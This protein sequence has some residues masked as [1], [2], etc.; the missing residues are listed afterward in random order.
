MVLIEETVAPQS[1]KTGIL[2]SGDEAAENKAT[3]EYAS[4]GFET[5]SKTDVIITNNDNHINDDEQI[6]R[7]DIQ[8]AQQRELNDDHH[9]HD[10]LTDHQ[11]KQKALED[12]NDAKLQGNNL[13]RSGQYDDALLKYDLALQLVAEVPSSEELRSACYLNRAT[14]FLKMEKYV[15]SI[16]DCTK[17]LEL[18][19]SYKK[20]LL[21]RAEAHEKLEHFEEAVA[22]MAK[23][24]EMEPSN[25]EVKRSA[26]RLEQLAR[27]KREKMKEEM[28]G[29]LKDVGNTLLGKFGM[30]VD[31]F[32][33]VQDPKTGSYSLSYQP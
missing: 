8:S 23:L 27:E 10:S 21:R 9:Y 14:C 19:P 32:K 17:A 13:Y 5:A 2:E 3:T 1:K 12:A 4:N 29:K 25:I 30:S 15:D 28:I 22:D 18:H 33:A 7:N 31:N 20:A 6:N 24:L 11:L 16:K 26:I